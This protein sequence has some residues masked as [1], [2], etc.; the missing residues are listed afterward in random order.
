MKNPTMQELMEYVDGVL[1]PSR[2]REIENMIAGS[3][4]LQKEIRMLTAMR[5]VVNRERIAPPKK[6]TSEIMNDIL[7][8]RQESIWF[9]LAKNSSNVFAMV[10]VL[11]LIVMALVSS[12]PPSSSTM[13]QLNTVFNSFSSSFNST[14]SQILSLVQEYTRPIDGA[15]KTILGKMLFIGLFIFSLLVIL[16]ELFGKRMM[17]R[18]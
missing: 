5:A 1:E 15:M 9:R 8:Q 4:S 2:H 3:K 13:N 17:V 16:D 14:F 10:V 7:P 18:K 12:S 11:T 6:F